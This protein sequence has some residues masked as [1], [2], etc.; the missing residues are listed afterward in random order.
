MQYVRLTTK[1]VIKLLN[2]VSEKEGFPAKDI[3][4]CIPKC[5]ESLGE[6]IYRK[7]IM[8]NDP[9][10][11]ILCSGK[12]ENILLT[13]KQKDN[14]HRC[15]GTHHSITSTLKE[16]LS[17]ELF[18][19]VLLRILNKDPRIKEIRLGD[20]SRVSFGFKY[21]DDGVYELTLKRLDIICN[22]VEMNSLL[23]KDSK[24]TESSFR[25]FG[26]ISTVV[27]PKEEIVHFLFKGQS[28][29]TRLLNNGNP[30]LYD[31]D[32]A[33]YYLIVKYGLKDIE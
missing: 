15:T 28:L 27:L 1:E 10:H 32:K 23:E 3:I 29:S 30:D 8:N 17:N 14:Y 25:E 20:I 11:V 19:E 22:K 2:E 21:I 18:M 13:S 4:G 6:A 9:F 5:D 7:L 33:M 26:E 16:E 12:N 31:F 24:D